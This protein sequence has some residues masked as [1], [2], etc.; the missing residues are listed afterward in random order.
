MVVRVP[1]QYF[2]LRRDGGTPSALHRAQEVPVMDDI[3]KG[4]AKKIQG[5][6]KEEAGK[7]AGDRS[8]EWGG[9]ADQ[10]KGELE[11]KAGEL[12]RDGHRDAGSDKPAAP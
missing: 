1:V 4:E 8:T 12:Q 9:K 11:K 2:V 10:V 6:V 7:V 3:I 5:K